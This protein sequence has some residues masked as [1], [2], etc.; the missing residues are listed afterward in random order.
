MRIFLGASAAIH[1]AIYST[2]WLSTVSPFSI[3]GLLKTLAS[4]SFVSVLFSLISRKDD[5]SLAQNVPL[6][7]AFMDN[8]PAFAWI[9][10]IEGRYVYVNKLLIARVTAFQSKW[11]GKTDADLWPGEIGATYCANDLKVVASRETL[12]TV[13]TYLLDGER[14]YLLVSKFPILDHTGAVTMVGGTG[15]DISAHQRAEDALREAENKYRDIFENAVEGIFQS[16]P[17]GQYVRANPAYACMLGYDST[18][19]MLRSRTDIA[20]QHYV[21]PAL[22]SEFKQLL[23]EYGVVRDFEHRAYR[24]DGRKIW[25]S[26]NVR[27]VCD[28]NGAV[29]YYEGFTEDITARKQAEE[30][31]DRL[32][33]LSL[34][35]LC[36]AGFDGYFKQVNPAWTQTLG[37]SEAELL[38]RPWIEFVHPDDHEATVKAGAALIASQ[39]V[40]GFENRYQHKDGSYRWFSWNSFPL[41]EAQLIYAVARNITERKRTENA[42]Q[43]SEERFRQLSEAAFE[44]IILHDQGTILEVN[45]SFCG[46]Y[47]YERAEV[48]GKSVLD[49]ALPEFR[50][51]LL[52]KVRAGDTGSYE[53]PALRKDGTTFRA[54]LAGKPIHYQGRT[55]RVAAIRDITEQKRNERRQAAQYAVT[56]VLAESAAFTDAIP[57]LLR[58]ICES[59]RW[60]MGEFWRVRDD[61]NLLR[62]VE[63]W[64]VPAL[65]VTSFIEASRKTEFAPGVGL[66]GRVWQSGQPAWI[67]DVMTD[68]GFARAAIAA[69]VGLRGAVAFPILLG[70]HPLGVMMFFS[71]RA[72]EVDEDLLKMMSAIGSQIGQ[73]TERKQIEGALRESEERYRDL[74]ENSRE[75]ICTHDLDGLVLSANRAT[76]KVL[77]YDPKDYCGK[78]N[79]REFLVP[80]VREQFDDY[81]ARIRRDG[82]AS[83]LMLMQTSSGER[84]DWEYYCTLRTEGVS[85]PIVRGMARDITERR[86]AEK[87]LRVSEQKYRDIFSFAPLG[88]CQSLPDGSLVTANKALATMLGYDSADELL[89]LKLDTDVYF[90]A[91]ER[92]ELITKYE[93]RGYAVDLEFQLKRKDGSPFWVQMNAHAVKGPGGAAEYFE[94]FVRDITESKRGEE[95]LRKQ[96]EYLA[97][98][99]ET[100]LGLI[101]RLDLK[102]L[103]EVI[104]ARACALVDIPSGYVYLLEPG[105]NEMS[106]KVGVGVSRDF[107][108]ALISKGQGVAGRIWETGQPLVVEDYRN[109]EHRLTN[110]GYDNLRLVGAVPLRS[111]SRV[112]GVLGVESTKE[113]QGLDKHQIEILNRFAQLASIALDNAQLHSAAQQELAE[114]KRTEEEITNLRR[115]LEL[116]MNSVEEGIHRMDM[117]GNIAYENPAAARMLGWEV[118]ELLGKPAHLTMHHTRQDGTPYP[119][120]ECPI[121]ATFRDGVSRH[122][123]DEVFWRQDGTSFPVEYMTAPMRNDRNEIVATVVTFRDITERT[124]ADEKLQNSERYFRS[125]I[126]NASDLITVSD[127][128]GIIRYESPSLERMLGYKPEE[129]MGKSVFE[130]LHPDDL[131][132][133][134]RHF[135]K[136]IQNPGIVH[137]MECRFQH[138]DGSW[139]LVETTGINLLDDPVV[140]GIV[141]NSRDITERKRAEEALRESEER[142][143]ELFENAKDTIYVHDLNG[144]YTS[145]NRAAEQLTGYSREEII[146]KHFSDFL[147]P[148]YLPRVRNHLVKKLTD[149]RPTSFEVEVIARDGR[150]VPVELSSNLVYEDGV[151]VGVQGIARDITERKRAEDALKA[152]SKQLRALSARLQS[153]KEEEGTRI[154][155][156][157]HDE[158][159]SALTS[160]RWS[161]DEIDS[162]LS[163]APSKVTTDA[164]RK[165]IATM[166]T[167]VEATLQTVRRISSELRPGILDEVG[168]IAAIEW[169]AEQFEART[170]IVCYVDSSVK[171]VHL[172]RQQSTAIFR[173]FQEALTNVLRHAEATRVDIAMTEAEGEFVLTISDDGRGITEEEKSG[174]K[175]LGLLG[176][177]ERAN[178]IGGEVNITSLENQGTAV[179]VRVP[180]LMA[181]P[182]EE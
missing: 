69:K 139:H 146:G 136:G 21:E 31:R 24:K 100:A 134:K 28:V 32:F 138:K 63:T 176:M 159:G 89:K 53:G 145:V 86:E 118:A 84:R 106:V 125:L 148:E 72:P 57:K 55:V 43:E 30:E 58:V 50:K 17:D 182:F 150:R 180:A 41:S 38:S 102:E 79:F 25:L 77:G 16:T 174:A 75:F 165:K 92:Q 23:E 113:G 142:Y 88:I 128:N 116:T 60:K 35:P 62:C 119:K 157:L 74:V 126:E 173:I 177:R 26:E 85:T 121:Y 20:R 13:E 135:A 98:L 169:E 178:L 166:T 10:D 167:L 6:F 33:N 51:L 114:R 91:G 81:L 96:N 154:A 52:Q 34:D 11:L 140:A 156:E 93:P 9:K 65:E 151:P 37:W 42:L 67:P 15:V 132:F 127:G 78:R 12:E 56:R 131:A 171:N 129:R 117:Q 54:E 8:L 80:E 172:T 47:G 66:P 107:V 161:L 18:E 168:P 103:L 7:S 90:V 94:A 111:G 109:W 29:L 27:S 83:G 152:T 99:H 115:E 64:H 22:R 162:L 133:A 175:S 48:I 95:S 59:L 68:Q 104:V 19:E 39:S 122:V 120:E 36:V 44:A 76:V 144:I 4:G 143:R 181:Q 82:V 97:A 71:P 158:L 73:S 170:G 3:A 163:T 123:A 141:V 130:L 87:A 101:N 49:L 40:L 70:N 5:E 46:M 179:T 153:A 137:F 147:A 105:G 108:G 14:R 45:Q 61:T 112:V 1:A 110:A 164:L 2:V 155:R 149:Q 124:R 160:L